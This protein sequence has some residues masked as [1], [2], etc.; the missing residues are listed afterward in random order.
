MTGFTEC[1]I[2]NAIMCA[3]TVVQNEKLVSAQF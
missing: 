3:Y 1:V 2:T